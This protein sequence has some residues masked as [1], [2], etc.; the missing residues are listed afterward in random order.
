MS[1]SALRVNNHHK[2]D[3][4]INSK[5]FLPFQEKIFIS[6]FHPLMI[7]SLFVKYLNSQRVEKM[8]CQMDLYISIPWPPS[9]ACAG[10][11]YM[12]FLL[13]KWTKDCT[14]L[15][16]QTKCEEARQERTCFKYFSI[17]NAMH[18]RSLTPSTFDLII[19]I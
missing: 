8:V 18:C 16:S 13:C 3:I 11:S 4:H 5:K 6:S 15:L 10:D 7:S 2:W 17:L 9:E 1:F 14:R 19:Y 12:W